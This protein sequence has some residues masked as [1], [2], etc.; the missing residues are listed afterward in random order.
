MPQKFKPRGLARGHYA[1]AL[2]EFRKADAAYY[3]GMVE[4]NIAR[5]DGVIAR[6]CR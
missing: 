3:V 5:L 1:A 4:G 6:L 2:E